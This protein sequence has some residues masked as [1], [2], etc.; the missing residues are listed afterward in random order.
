MAILL[1]MKL[2]NL[3]SLNDEPAAF[4]ASSNARLSWLKR[5]SKD[6][7][8]NIFNPTDIDDVKLVAEAMEQHAKSEEYVYPYCTC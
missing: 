2:A 1:F 4:P 8:D 7:V 3:S 5:I 6:L